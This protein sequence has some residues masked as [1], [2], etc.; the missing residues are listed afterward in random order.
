[1]EKQQE[2]F[3]ND[4][5]FKAFNAATCS[6][7][8]QR[9][10]I[11]KEI[12]LKELRNYLVSNGYNFN[13]FDKDSSIARCFDA[14]NLAVEAFMYGAA[15]AYDYM[16]TFWFPFVQEEM[17]IV[18]VYFNEIQQKSLNSKWS[19]LKGWDKAIS[20]GDGI[21]KICTLLFVLRNHGLI[22]FKYD[23]L[24]YTTCKEVNVQ[25]IFGDLMPDIDTAICWFSTDNSNAVLPKLYKA[26]KK[27]IKDLDI[28]IIR[29]LEGT[30][31]I[32]FFAANGGVE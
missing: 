16:K 10:K 30:R 23:S 15:S 8:E 2:K 25:R 9:L 24:A 13:V 4:V 20:K 17:D 3:I 12:D 22:G 27:N 1:M 18:Q 31:K 19:K 32:D 11:L 21:E 26:A 29:F 28:E 14:S 7:S 6:S 5:L